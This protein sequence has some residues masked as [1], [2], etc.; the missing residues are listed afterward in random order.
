MKIEA[1]WCKFDICIIFRRSKKPQI[2]FCF[3]QIGHLKQNL[4]PF[5][6]WARDRDLGKIIT[7]TIFK[8]RYLPHTDSFFRAIFFLF[9]G[10]ISWS[11]HWCRWF[12]ISVPEFFYKSQ[13]PIF[14]TLNAWYG[15]IQTP[16]QVPFFLKVHFFLSII[17]ICN[18]FLGYVDRNTT[19]KNRP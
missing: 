6:F 5:D 8:Q 12:E 4:E 17:Q 15:L 9:W 11:I 3:I 19:F 1:C 18:Q 7:A 14:A 13:I 10:R 2:R 16:N